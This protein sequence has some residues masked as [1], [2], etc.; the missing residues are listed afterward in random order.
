[1]TKNASRSFAMTTPREIEDDVD[2]PSSEVP[3]Q[4]PPTLGEMLKAIDET[5]GLGVLSDE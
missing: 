2:S 1:M 4:S 5:V 3:S